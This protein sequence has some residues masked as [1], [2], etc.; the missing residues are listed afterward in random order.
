MKRTGLLSLIL[1]GIFMLVL[2]GTIWAK[3]GHPN[4][5]PG[6]KF[7]SWKVHRNYYW[8]PYSA[9]TPQ[10][11]VWDGIGYRYYFGG[12]DYVITPTASTVKRSEV[13][14]AVCEDT[15]GSPEDRLVQL[16]ALTDLIH[17]WRTMNESPEFHARISGTQNQPEKIRQIL[18]NIKEENQKFDESSRAA[19]RDL[20]AGKSAAIN[21]QIVQ[22]HLAT[23]TGLADSLP[24]V[25]KETKSKP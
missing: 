23:L 2:A 16:E 22:K 13:H 10:A 9:N 15:T 6:P 12:T 18:A 17:G 1:G 21:L 8:Y 3:S 20:A 5:Q 11:R 19:M 25:K 14:K 7:F 4:R 24:E